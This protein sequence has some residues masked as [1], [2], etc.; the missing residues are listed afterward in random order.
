MNNRLKF[1]N[2]KLQQYLVMYRY[3][4]DYDIFVMY[5]FK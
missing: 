3:Y 1:I 4:F 2:M 5:F